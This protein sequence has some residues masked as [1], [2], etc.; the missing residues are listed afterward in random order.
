MQQ[1]QTI[2]WQRGA[3]EVTRIVVR[4]GPLAGV[5]PILLE[6]AFS[7]AKC[8]TVADQ[9][10]LE[11][12]DSELRLLCRDC[13][14]ESVASINRMICGHCGNW[15]TSVVSG[16]ELLLASLELVTAGKITASSGQH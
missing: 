5:E 1:V 12:E 4:I 13:G 11:I 10:R 2:A 14:N 9:A 15:Q 16:D 6:R 8:G 7:V 3:S